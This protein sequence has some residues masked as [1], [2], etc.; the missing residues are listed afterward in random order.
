MREWLNELGT[1][2]EA[3]ADYYVALLQEEIRRELLDQGIADTDPRYKDK[4]KNRVSEEIKLLLGKVNDL[5]R[6]FWWNEW[7]DANHRRVSGTYGVPRRN[8]DGLMAS[9]LGILQV[10][11]HSVCARCPP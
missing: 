10:P 3:A 8:A 11:G 6:P 4:L 7:A 2:G 9:L 1:S 5:M